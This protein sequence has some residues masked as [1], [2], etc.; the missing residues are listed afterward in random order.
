MDGTQGRGADSNCYE[1]YFIREDGLKLLLAGLGETQWY[2]LFSEA[3][4]SANRILADLYQSGV[5]DWE[6]AGAAVRQPYAGMLAAMLEKKTC[7][8]IHLPDPAAPV[9][10]CYL[11]R[12]GMVMTQK[13][14]REDRTLGMA[15]LSAESWLGLLEEECARL[16]DGESCLLTRRSSRDGQVQATIRICRDGLRSYRMESDAGPA[17][18]VCCEREAFGNRLRE[19]L[20]TDEAT[21]RYMH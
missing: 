2:G 19:M 9:R 14:R 15:K 12:T 18:L 16:D 7:V 13:S 11:S 4:G 17:R 8:T 6:G 1:L 21:G 20:Q 10:C 5:I 3:N